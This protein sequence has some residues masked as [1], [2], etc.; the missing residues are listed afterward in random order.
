[1]VEKKIDEYEAKIDK[2][3]MREKRSED[4]S[5]VES[6][7]DLSTRKI[8]F[9]LMKKKIID[10][11]F[12]AISTGKEA[13]VYRAI[14]YDGNDLCLKIYRT[15]SAEIQFMWKYIEGDPRFTHVRKKPRNIVYAWAEKEYKNLSRAM[16]ADVRVPE[17]IIS[18]KNIL[19]MEFIG[20]DHLPAPKLKDVQ[21]KKPSKVFNMIIEYINRLYN[22]ANLVHSD[23]S[24]FNILM[25]DEEPV[26]IDISQAVPLDHP[27]SKKFL[28]RD[29]KN[30]HWFFSK[31]GL[32][33]PEVK[34]IYDY[35]ITGE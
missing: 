5:T 18:I 12:G 2:S 4:L 21:I 17:P 1:L 20:K 6:V 10:E 9:Q 35:I 23:L 27:Y 11:I 31:L 26:I 29:I 32:N 15:K 19:V 30:I 13:N 16:E 24:E 14:D 28:L 7:F 3:R 34:E 25:D 8:V 33:L 22:N